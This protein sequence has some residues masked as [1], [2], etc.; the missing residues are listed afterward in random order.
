MKYKNLLFIMA[1]ISKYISY[2]QLFKDIRVPSHLLFVYVNKAS[3][4]GYSGTGYSGKTPYFWNR[5]FIQKKSNLVI[6]REQIVFFMQLIFK[7]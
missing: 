3:C 5:L 1:I 2:I 7:I 4:P 6:L